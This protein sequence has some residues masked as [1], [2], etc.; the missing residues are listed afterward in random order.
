MLELIGDERDELHDFRDYAEDPCDF[1]PE[2][3][4]CGSQ[5][6]EVSHP[7]DE[8]NSPGGCECMACGHSWTF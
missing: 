6:I 4:E 1:G 3:P 7:E 5:D 8:T 2:C